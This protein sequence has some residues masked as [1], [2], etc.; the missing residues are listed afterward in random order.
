MD[1]KMKKLTSKIDLFKTDLVIFNREYHEILKASGLDSF[2]AIYAY[3]EGEVIKKIRDRSV[4]RMEIPKPDNPEIGN[5]ESG[6]KRF[7]LKKS[8]REYIG[9]RRLFKSLF[10]KRICSQGY[11]ELENILTFREHDLA[12]AEPVAAGQKFIRFFW[13]ESFVI[14][15]DYF[16]FISLEDLLKEKP[17]FFRGP[18][19]IRKK[20]ILLEKI[21]RLARKMHQSGLNHRDFNS[22]HILLWYDD[23]SDTPELALY[24]LQRVNRRKFFRF[25]WVIKSLAEL[26]YT[27]PEN[28]F[29]ENDRIALFLAYKRNG[30]P[31]APEQ[32]NLNFRDRIQ[33]F[34][35]RRK[36]GRIKRHTEK[37]NALKKS[38]I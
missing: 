38:K 33:L 28:L 8:N 6:T 17:E 5:P 7:Y 31:P 9:I 29:E 16:P 15:E 37:R 18:D 23:Q 20:K 25:R 21:G 14:T 12:T 19:G 30:A 34:W 11:L 4:I 24:D 27:L 10:P 3:H 36:A 1:S 13:A 26:S 22:N 2:E 35:I 32:A